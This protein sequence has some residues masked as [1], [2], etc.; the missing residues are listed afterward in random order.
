MLKKKTKRNGASSFIPSF[1]I[2]EVHI[3][4]HPWTE[5]FCQVLRSNLPIPISKDAEGRSDQMFGHVIFQKS[6]S[7]VYIIAGS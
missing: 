7:I 3:H 6:S 1:G 2:A 4:G 5:P